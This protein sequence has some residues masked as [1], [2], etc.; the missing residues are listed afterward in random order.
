MFVD[1][2]NVNDMNVCWLLESFLCTY[3]AFFEEII[4]VYVFGKKY[5]NN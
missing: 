2:Y 5:V 4:D 3:V 1:T